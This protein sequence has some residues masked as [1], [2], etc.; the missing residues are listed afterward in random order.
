MDN[1]TNPQNDQK[2]SDRTAEETASTQAKSQEQ[3]EKCVLGSVCS[4]ISKGVEDAMNAAEKAIPKVKAAVTD[5]A[6][7]TAYGVSF[8]V[9]WHWTVARHL[10]PECLKSGYRDG[11]KAGREAA[12]KWVDQLKTGKQGATAASPDQTG[13]STEGAQAGVV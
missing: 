9:V 5:A 10:T 4:A 8:A 6:Y 3:P 13:P 12:E 11:A 7:W 2:A 1:T